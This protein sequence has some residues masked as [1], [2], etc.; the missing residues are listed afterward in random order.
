MKTC[1]WILAVILA[2]GGPVTRWQVDSCDALHEWTLQALAWRER[3]NLKTNVLAACFW[4]DE[5]LRK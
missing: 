5:P 3:S 4:S 1:I 2:H